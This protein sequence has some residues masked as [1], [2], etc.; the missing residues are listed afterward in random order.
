MMSVEWHKLQ[1]IQDP[2][3]MQERL[4]EYKH[5]NIFLFL[6]LWKH[7]YIHSILKRQVELEDLLL[8]EYNTLEPRY[9]AKVSYTLQYA[10]Y[11]RQWMKS[12]G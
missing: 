6:Y 4:R 2:A 3:L 10:R 9:Q 5:N 7:A 11:V 8:N 1:Q 12:N